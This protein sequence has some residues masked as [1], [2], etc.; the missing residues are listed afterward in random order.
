VPVTVSTTVPPGAAGADTA[1][2][3]FSVVGVPLGAV[4]APLEAADGGKAQAALELGERRY[5]IPSG[6]GATLSLLRGGASVADASFVVSTVQSSWLTAPGVGAVLLLL[7]S[8]AYVESLLRSLRRGQRRM[9]AMASLSVIGL[10]LGVSVALLAWIATGRP[11]SSAGLV[12]C[13]L[14]GSASAVTAGASA[15]HLA[16]RRRFATRGP[17]LGR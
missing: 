5:L 4:T 13:A 1:Q 7:F 15:M 12:L 8:A 16:R 10:A 11:P 17:L 9:V 6:T 3:S 2:L 14:L